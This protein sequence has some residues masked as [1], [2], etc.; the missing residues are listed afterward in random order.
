VNTAVE[1]VDQA[2][3]WDRFNVLWH[4]LFTATVGIPVIIV[5]VAADVTWSRK[6]LVLAAAAVLVAGHW[7]VL[8]RHPQWWEKRLGVMTVYWAVVCALTAVLALQSPSFV[9]TLY[10]LYPLMFMTMGW[11][12]IVP[13]VGVTALV[14]WA[15]GGWGSGQAMITNLL[16]TAGLALIIAVFVSAISKQSEQRRA[17]L[18]ELAATRA[19]LAESARQTGALAERE[20]LARELHDTVAQGF[21]SVV[22]QLESAEQAL[23]E[24]ADEK[25]VVHAR[26]HVAKARRSARDSLAEIRQSVRALRP[27]LLSSATLG[28]A[29]DR[30]VRQWSSD[31]GVPAELRTTGEPMSLTPDVEL[32]LLRAVQEALANVARHA[33]ASRVVVSLSYLGD[34]VT[35]DVDDDGN[36]FAGK[37]RPSAE[38]GYGLIGMRERVAAVGG[39]LTIESAA[40]QGTTVGVSVPA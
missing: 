27:D 7:L 5:L 22:T 15:L 36:G 12:G 30:T 1:P 26:E 10:G 29:L 21:T 34:T 20:R 25:A 24:P 19:E 28:E 8:A 23:E 11:W 31:T 38:G 39:E 9:I 6:L 18:T 33:S 13:I 17:A 40:G 16:T 32:T 4:L 37:P 35:L 2:D 14:G 3:V